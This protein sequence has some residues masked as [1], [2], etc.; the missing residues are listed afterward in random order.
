VST[1]A[2]ERGEVIVGEFS[3]VRELAQV[4]AGVRIGTHVLVADGA[5]VGDRV[6]IESSTQVWAGVTLGDDV[7]VGPNATFAT[8]RFPRSG[9]HD[10]PRQ[11]IVVRR[12]ATIG[13]G[14]TLLPGVEVGEGAMVGAGAVVTRSVP[15]EAIVVG[16]PARIVGYVETGRDA[17]LRPVRATGADVDALAT[18]TTAVRGVMLHELPVIRDLR[19]SL[20]A[21]ELARGLPFIPQRYF[22]VFDVPGVDVRGEHAHRACHQFL[23][24]VHGEVHVVADDGQHRQEFVLDHQ[25]RGLHLPPMTW[26]IQ[27]RYAPGST[28]LVL[29]SDPYD[30][31]DYIRDYDEFLLAVRTA[32]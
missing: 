18:T 12:W 22:M 28:L 29:A 21:G 13:A 26:G 24:C 6:T 19:G 14:A 3:V 5:V 2:A 4:G 11:P 20:V 16:N 7:F 15:R 9:Q 8:E 27:Y 10:A 32:A 30:P 1:G 31:D 25:G 17:V 23:I